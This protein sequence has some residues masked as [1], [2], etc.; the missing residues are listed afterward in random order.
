MSKVWKEVKISVCDAEQ[1]VTI[2]PELATNGGTIVMRSR[3]EED[4]GRDFLLYLKPEEAGVLA[5]ELIRLAQ[6]I[7]SE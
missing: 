4:K 5:D 7:K 3:E 2:F 6:E 1:S